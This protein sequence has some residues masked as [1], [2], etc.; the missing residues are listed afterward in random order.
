MVA[1]LFSEPESL[2]LFTCR[3]IVHLRRLCAPGCVC[4]SLQQHLSRVGVGQVREVRRGDSV[5]Y[6]WQAGA[7]HSIHVTACHPHPVFRLPCPHPQHHLLAPS[8]PPPDPPSIRAHLAVVDAFGDPDRRK[9]P[10]PSDALNV[11]TGRGLCR[12]T[13]KG[14]PK[15]RQERER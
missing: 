12:C 15:R 4:R 5:I 7:G 6:Q 14:L 10:M 1:R 11:R 3:I 2:V 13:R 9:S 8:T